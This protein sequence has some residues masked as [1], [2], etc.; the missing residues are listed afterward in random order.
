MRTEMNENRN[1]NESKYIV[2]ADKV[3]E[4]AQQIRKNRPIVHCI[5]NAVTVNDCA[6]ILLAVGASPTMA[7][8]PLEV[9][10]ITAG[11]AA[12]VCNF[13][14]TCDYEAML[15]AGEKA[16]VLDHPIVVDPVGVSGSGYRRGLCLEFLEKIHPTCIRGNYSEIRA[17]MENHSTVTGVDAAVTELG[18]SGTGQDTVAEEAKRQQFFEQMKEFARQHK[19]ILIASGAVDLITDG[20]THYQVYNGHSDMARIT[21]SGCMSSVMLGAFF[22]Q[23]KSVQGAVASCGWMGI[24]GELAAERTREVCG[25]TMTFRE[26]FIDAVSLMEHEK[27]ERL[28]VHL[29]M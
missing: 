7:H 19:V 10:E 13:G 21:G 20:N 22:S 29:D 24:A 8:H 6:N 17:L 9:E 14:A 4:L 28:H 18:V 27:L 5:T 26:K 2:S 1:M 16:R 12:L 3:W 15:T 25:G 11:A 23:E